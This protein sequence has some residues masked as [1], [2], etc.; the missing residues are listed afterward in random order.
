MKRSTFLTISAIVPLLV[1]L[2]CLT[3]PSVLVEDVKV[4]A[5]SATANVFVRTVGVLLC[6]VALL[7]FMVRN[8]PDSPTLRAVLFADLGLQLAILPI[9]PH[10]YARGVFT[11]LGSFVPNT[12]L[13]VCIAAGCVYYLVQMKR[14]AARSPSF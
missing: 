14:T 3:A 1:G 6:T 4:A 12:I 10:A 8:H 11:T 7:N 9:D 2:L 13:H 5:P